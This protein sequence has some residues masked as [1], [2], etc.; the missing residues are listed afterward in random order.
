MAQK[1][2]LAMIGVGRLGVAHALHVAE[3]TSE[4]EGREFGAAVEVRSA[5][6]RCFP[7]WVQ[8]AWAKSTWPRTRPW[9]PR[10]R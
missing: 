1:V 7:Y 4:T 3:V 8:E 10:W 6:M 9:S 2:E 5:P